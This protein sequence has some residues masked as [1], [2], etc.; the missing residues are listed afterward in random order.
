MILLINACVRAGSR[1]KRLADYLLSQL[2]D[3]VAERRLS[4]ITFPAVNEDFLRRRDS[5]IAKGASDDPLFQY[6]REFAGADTIVIAAPYWDLSFPADLKRYLEQI[7]VVGITF[8]YSSDG[9]PVGLCRAKKLFY[10]TTAGGEYAPTDY[11]FGYVK[12]L[13]KSFY[14][15]PDVRLIQATG[16]DMIGADESAILQDCRKRIDETVS[17]SD[18]S[19]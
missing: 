4:E 9:I 12:E 16:L 3:T 7:N 6:A 18:T 1:T 13:A 14:G 5:L 17:L 11:G 19:D 2:N 15:I 8:R 10:V